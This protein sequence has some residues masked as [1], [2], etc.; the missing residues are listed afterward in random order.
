MSEKAVGG[1]ALALTTISGSTY[2]TFAKPLTSALSPLS[3][4]FVSEL[5]TGFFVMLSFGAVPTIKRI[6][7]LDRKLYLPLACVGLF[8]S[9]LGPMLWFTGLRMTTVV[10][11]SLFAKV[12]LIIVL[13]LA[14]FFLNER[15]TRTHLLAVLAVAVG[16]IF[17][18]MRGFTAGLE[19]K[20]A[21]GI[22]VLSVLS[23]AA[24]GVTFR[25]YLHHVEP[26]VT[27]F[28]RTLIAVGMFFAISPFIA[29]PFIT[30]LRSF[31]AALIP[32]LLG[33]GF[34]ARF[35]NIFTYYQALERLPV[36]T[37][38]MTLTLDTIGSAFC[39]WWFLGESIEWYHIAGG[40]AIV[41]GNLLLELAGTHPTEELKKRIMK[42]RVAHRP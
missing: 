9:V 2:N 28:A 36:V 14:R 11:A 1:V 20:L 33:F 3:L 19:P 42:H 37:V 17:I 23:Y 15:L 31:P 5:L 40:G 4:L 10:N 30:E 41:G 24:G 34:I 27:L 32:A 12:D 6:M 26:H 7:K 21:D 8:S 39:A 35:I 25:K 29:H 16:I 18:A 13:L 22:I 38:S